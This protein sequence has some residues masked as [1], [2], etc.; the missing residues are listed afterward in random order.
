MKLFKKSLK[1]LLAFLAIVGIVIVSIIHVFGNFYK[2]NEGVY[3]SGQ[4]NKYNLEY[5]LKHKKIKTIVNL[6][7]TSTKQYYKTER[8]LAQKYHVDYVTYGISNK[9]F[10]DF[11]KTSQIVHILKNAQ[12]PI[13]IHCNGGADRTSLAAALYQ[14]AIAGY[15]IEKAKEEFSFLYGHIP[16]FR[17][18]VLAMDKSFENYVQKAKQNKEKQ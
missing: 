10:L 14:Y 11:N 9:V 7:G 1:Y 17:P 5:Y 3:R 4:L 12:K 16:F 8:A 2:V 13:L 18:H 6:R 15:S